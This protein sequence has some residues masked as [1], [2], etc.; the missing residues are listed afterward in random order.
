MNALLTPGAAAPARGLTIA[1][2][3]AAL[4]VTIGVT[5]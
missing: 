3:I 2:F 4:A 1:V 5:F